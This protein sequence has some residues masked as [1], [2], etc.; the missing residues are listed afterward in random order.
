[1]LVVL[2]RKLTRTLGAQM[3]MI[4]DEWTT[5]LLCTEREK[6]CASVQDS[7]VE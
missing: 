1:M 6:V 2:Q 3:I 7:E 5:L 4:L